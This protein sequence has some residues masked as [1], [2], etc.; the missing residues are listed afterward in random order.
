VRPGVFA[1]AAEWT[2]AKPEAR[3]VARARA[4]ARVSSAAPVFSHE[5]AAALHGLPLYRADSKRV[6]TIA[7]AARP[8]RAGDVIRHRGDL[9]GDDVI[10]V[11]GLRCTTLERTVSDVARTAT[12]EQAVTVADAALRLRCVDG[13]GRYDTG[14]AAEFLQAA[15][16]IS[17]Q[18]AHGQTRARRTFEFADGRAQLPGESISRI[19][20]RELGFREL[21]LQ[22]HVPG[23]NGKDYYVDFGLEEV[24]S[25]GEFD[26]TIKYVDGKLVDGRGSSQV[27]DEEKQRE[28]WIRG[29]TQR[30]YGRWGWPHVA[31][32]AKLGQRLG[33]FGIRPP[34]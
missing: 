23:P 16:E 25:F 24:R 15:T 17:R 34:R 4:L 26:G 32:A 20:L 18:S 28:D 19:R 11:D 2:D 1:R 30:R 22:V 6:H 7:S 31:S 10:E 12:F 5:T 9:T 27:L 13:P 14:R 21:H 3:V 33:A 8:G 29:T